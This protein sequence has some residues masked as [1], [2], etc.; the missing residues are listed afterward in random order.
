[1][2][3]NYLGSYDMLVLDAR[4]GRFL[5]VVDH[6]ETL[7]ATLAT[8]LGMLPQRGVCMSP[9]RRDLVPGR[10]ELPSCRS[11]PCLYVA[12]LRPYVCAD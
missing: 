3:N 7:A 1:M 6:K 4:F 11:A 10:R 9:A 2:M 8:L 5:P 12:A